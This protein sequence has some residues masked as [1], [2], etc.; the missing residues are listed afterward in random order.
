MPRSGARSTSR[1]NSAISTR[2]AR[3]NRGPDCP[4]RAEN[5]CPGKA[6]KQDGPCKRPVRGNCSDV[7]PDCGNQRLCEDCFQMEEHH[8]QYLLI[9][10]MQDQARFVERQQETMV[11]EAQRA[12]RARLDREGMNAV[13]ADVRK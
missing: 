9:Q 12:E 5:R 8:C 7:C 4:P 11:L 3:W 13:I 1:S 2:E 10:A 6:H